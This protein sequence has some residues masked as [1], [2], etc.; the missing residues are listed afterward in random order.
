MSLGHHFWPFLGVGKLSVLRTAA[1][2]ARENAYVPY[3]HFAVG[4]AVRVGD[5]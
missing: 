5:R 3:S 4:A 2:A 1:L